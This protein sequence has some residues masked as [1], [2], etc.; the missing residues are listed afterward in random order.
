[1]RDGNK[2]GDEI[3]TGRGMKSV[4]FR[5]RKGV[6]LMLALL[7]ILIGSTVA[8]IIYDIA[9]TF[10]WQ[11]LRQREIYV[12]HTTMLDAVQTIKGFIIHANSTDMK[13]MHTPNYVFSD[14]TS[15]IGSP[16]NLRFDPVRVPDSPLSLNCD[17]VVSNGTGIQRLKIS[18]YDLC[19]KTSDLEASLRSDGNQMRELPSPF[20]RE[21]VTAG[22][23]G[24][25]SV[26]DALV[27]GDLAPPL[28][29]PGSALNLEK[30]GTYLIRVRLHDA[31]G[32]GR[33]LV[34][35]VEEAF[36]QV[37]P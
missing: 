28:G 10:S 31:E 35:T 37:L 2:T 26:G 4:I 20:M 21:G 1:M 3:G 7:V 16:S 15:K 14:D 25:N 32:G 30:Y 23:G 19:Y 6:A 17:V 12:D 29:D 5:R 36:T 11:G 18:V 33:K 22:G 34:R 13:V 8:A 24:M 9:F 27:V